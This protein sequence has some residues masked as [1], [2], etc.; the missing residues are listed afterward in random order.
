MTVAFAFGF[1]LDGVW[2]PEPVRQ[3]LHDLTE[4]ALEP[5]RRALARIGRSGDAPESRRSRPL[6]PFSPPNAPTPIR[7]AAPHPP[8]DR[9][10]PHCS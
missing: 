10:T 6:D 8:S 3:H 9:D 5:G 4:R 2:P 1:R 7:L